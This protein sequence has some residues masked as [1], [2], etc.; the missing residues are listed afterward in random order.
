M[1]NKKIEHMVVLEEN[2][3]AE[4]TPQSQPP[5]KIPN[6]NVLSN[7]S[8]YKQGQAHLHTDG[9]SPL[10]QGNPGEDRNFTEDSQELEK[11]QRFG[12]RKS[13]PPALKS[14]RPKEVKKPFVY[15]NFVSNSLFK[16]EKEKKNTDSNSNNPTTSV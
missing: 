14:D 6:F 4:N 10:S 9:S 11:V 8:A 13:I 2:S 12:P 1:T 16:F 15:R 5:A 3:Q 7:F